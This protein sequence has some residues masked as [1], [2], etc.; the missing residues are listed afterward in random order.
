MPLYDQNPR[1]IRELSCHHGGPRQ[2]DLL[3]QISPTSDEIG[4][5]LDPMYQESPVHSV[6]AVEYILVNGLIATL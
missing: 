4:S 2:I 1:Y 5:Q 6:N 3:Y